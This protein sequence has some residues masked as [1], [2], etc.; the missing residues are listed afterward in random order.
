MLNKHYFYAPFNGSITAADLR[1]GS[2][3]RAG[4]RL[5]EIINLSNLELARA[6]AGGGYRLD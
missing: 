6:G 3:V 4:S 1:V 5:G 2:N